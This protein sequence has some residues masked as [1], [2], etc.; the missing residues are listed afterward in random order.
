MLYLMVKTIRETGLKYLCKCGDYKDPFEYKGSGRYWCRVLAKHPEYHVDTEIIGTYQSNEELREA[1]LHYSKLW[2]VVESK[3]WANCIP[4][5]GDG[6]PTVSGMTPIW[7]P[8]TGERRYIGKED[9]VPNGWK[10]GQPGYKRPKEATKRIAAA[11]RGMKRPDVT[12][13][14]MKDAWSE[15]KRKPFTRRECSCGRRIV[16]MN[17]DRH[18]KVCKG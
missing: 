8:K 12:K 17:W 14:R 2:N 5:L 6:G 4:E 3:E 16:P 18:Q 11:H 10:K 1:G 7:N 15:G 13:Q 9:V